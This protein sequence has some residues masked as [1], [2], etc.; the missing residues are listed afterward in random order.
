MAVAI[1]QRLQ[2]REAQSFAKGRLGHVYECR[3][4]YQ[5][6]IDLTQ[7][8]LIA[9]VANESLYLWAWQAGRLFKT[10]GRVNEAIDFYEKSVLSLKSTRSDLALQQQDFQFDFRDNVEPVYRELIELRLQQNSQLERES[11][12]QQNLKSVLKT[13]DEL[14]LAELQNYLGNDCALAPSRLKFP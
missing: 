12:I 7:Q 2:D 9:T 10:Q 13:V 3:Q 8:A 14:R 5:Q 11:G 1:A 6:A 4:D